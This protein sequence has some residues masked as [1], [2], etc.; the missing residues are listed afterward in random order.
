MRMC[1]KLVGRCVERTP[2]EILVDA[3]WKILGP[4][5]YYLP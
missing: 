2:T 5:A 1:G 4:T 3:L